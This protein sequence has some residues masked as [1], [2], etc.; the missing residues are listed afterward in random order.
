MDGEA[1][2][3][4]LLQA[5]F[6]FLRHFN[7]ATDAAGSLAWAMEHRL[8]AAFA[9]HATVV[10][11][12]AGDA[13]TAQN[14]MQCAS[15]RGWRVQYRATDRSAAAIG[16][17]ARDGNGQGLE[18]GI[19]DLLHAPQVLGR[20]SA[21]VA[22]ASLVLHHLSDAEVVQALR[23]MGAVARRLVVWND[24][25]RDRAGVLGA[26]LTS[27]FAGRE[28]RAD[29]VRSVER[30]FTMGEAISFAE[31]AGLQQIE[32]RR[33]RGARFVLCAVPAK[34]EAEEAEVA[35]VEMG[36][37]P[38]AAGTDAP[39][40]GVLRAR[41]MIRA[42]RV[43]IAFGGRTVLREFSIEVRS[44]Q[45]VTLE[46]PN[47]AGKSTLLRVLAGAIAPDAGRAWCD[48][49]LGPV[50][51]LPQQA[52]LMSEL[53][54]L[55]NCA[56]PARLAGASRAVAGDRAREWMHRFYPDAQARASVRQLSVGQS[57][58]IALASVFALEPGCLL[59]DEP[60]SGL[61]V[62]GRARLAEAVIG[63]ARRGA[64]T[65]FATHDAAWVAAACQSAGIPCRRVALP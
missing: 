13:A 49:V 39:R 59:L 55:A 21:D 17:A 53:G 7:R 25:V 60:D 27:A 5:E 20:A 2:D 64:S 36:V 46:G 63:A 44:G 22:F 43:S 52:G 33:W 14:F 47:G 50:G 3:A 41:P 61:D 34:G 24:L 30:S 10:E 65:L 51:Y 11:L 8:G 29:A 57:R 4:A 48:R 62:D 37:G 42:D 1:P 18:L 31:A 32:V 15:K 54:A 28:V 56:L 12:G 6:R 9:A 19:A 23:G 16:L 58:R 38:G 40:T 45:V 26:R 35:E